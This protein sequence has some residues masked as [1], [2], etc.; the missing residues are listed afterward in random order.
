MII[1]IPG[2]EEININNIVFDYNGTIAVGG[3]I[4]LSIVDKL[5]SLTSIVN[6][7]VL[8]ADTYGDAKK[9]C[10]EIG[11]N[12]ITF[13]GEGAGNK[14]KAIV[15]DFGA[16]NCLC[17]GNGYNDIPMCK[18][19]GLSIGVIEGEGICSSLIGAVDI[20][21]SSIESA[22]DMILNEKRIIATLRN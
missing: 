21:H 13:E 11:I 6:C 15:E 20:V 14:K 18:I 3:K 22:I 17:I 4:K 7:V 12:I 1:K 5:K 19:A 10:D 2:R 16:E 9:Q 8:T